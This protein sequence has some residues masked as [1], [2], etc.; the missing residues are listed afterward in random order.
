MR[1]LARH[2]GPERAQRRAWWYRDQLMH[3][4]E[5][6]RRAGGDCAQFGPTG[7]P[8]ASH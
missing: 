6:Y 1:T 3:T 7:A 8:P 4:S 5:L 2:R